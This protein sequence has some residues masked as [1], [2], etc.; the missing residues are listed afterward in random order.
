MNPRILRMVLPAVSLA[1]LLAG[2]A[3][4]Y[5]NAAN[6]RAGATEADVLAAIGAPNARHAMPGGETR[7]EY[8]HGP[9]GEQTF[10]VDMDSQGRMIRW[11]QVLSEDTFNTVTPGMT[12]AQLQA[13]VGRPGTVGGMALQPGELWV[14]RYRSMFCTLWQAHLVQGV[15]VGAGYTPDPRCIAGTER[16][17]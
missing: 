15:V 14:Y 17:H 4:G 11:Q 5:P 12:A 13:R 9:Q 6:L 3:A 16:P 7:L 8:A 1:A 2:C 10:M